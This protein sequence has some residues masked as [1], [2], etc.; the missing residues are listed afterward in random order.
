MT[1]AGDLQLLLQD[2]DDQFA[3][4]VVRWA[5][6]VRPQVR[7]RI[8]KKLDLATAANVMAPGLDAYYAAI[9]ADERS[10]EL[11][12]TDPSGLSGYELFQ[13]WC[14]KRDKEDKAQE[15]LDDC[16]PLRSNS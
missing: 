2:A 14:A 6:S 10:N 16:F 9:E 8:L 5:R 4:A 1:V 11:F 7:A 13:V 12:C 15:V 3:R